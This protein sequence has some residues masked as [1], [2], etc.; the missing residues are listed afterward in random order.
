MRRLTSIQT[1]RNIAAAAAAGLLICS[2]AQ[3]EQIFMVR[4]KGSAVVFTN[5]PLK[6]DTVVGVF[7]PQVS[8]FS[9]THAAR[10]ARDPQLA[11]KYHDLITS[12]SRE[13]GIDPALVKAMVHTESAFN[14][15]ATS[16]KGAIGLMQLMPATARSVGVLNPY[17]P[18]ENLRGGVYYLASLIEKYKGN[19]TLSLAAYNAGPDAVDSFGGIPPYRETQQYVRKVLALQQA[20]Q[21][22]EA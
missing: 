14:P 2:A 21:K 8:R 3:A 11:L 15:R 7:S 9:V 6:S 18:E 5:R 12:V 22:G 20:Y 4:G 17:K 1:C 19:L 16:R 10:R 13:A